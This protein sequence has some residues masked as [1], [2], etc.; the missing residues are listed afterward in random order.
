MGRGEPM[1]LRIFLS[2]ADLRSMGRLPQTW[3]PLEIDPILGIKKNYKKG[4]GGMGIVKD[5]I[6]ILP[7]GP[8]QNHDFP[9]GVSVTGARE[10][11]SRNTLMG[12]EVTRE[13]KGMRG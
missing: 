12:Q 6:A 4:G 13:E 8:T 11:V 1:Q 9:L 5:Y 3:V 2:S 7:Y 10:T